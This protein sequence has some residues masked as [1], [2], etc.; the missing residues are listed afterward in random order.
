[1]SRTK[2]VW[3]EVEVDVDLADFDTSD[4]IE[5]LESRGSGTVN[6]G[7]NKEL[8][9]KIYLLRRNG[10]DYQVELDA[11]IYSGLGKIV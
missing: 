2:T 5:E 11:L 7:G 8:L 9:E 6:H 10:R 1:M 4:L 3:S